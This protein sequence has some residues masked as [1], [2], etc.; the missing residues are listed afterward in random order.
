MGVGESLEVDGGAERFRD[1]TGGGVGF[2]SPAGRVRGRR[3]AAPSAFVVAAAGLLMAAG[4]ALCFV[5]RLRAAGRALR[6][7]TKRRGAPFTKARVRGTRKRQGRSS[8]H[9]SASPLARILNLLRRRAQDYG[10]HGLSRI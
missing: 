4:R 2:V 3:R 8:R 10:F 6:A 9:E 7:D 5:V 1:L